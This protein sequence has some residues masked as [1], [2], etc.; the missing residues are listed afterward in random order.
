MARRGTGAPARA[1]APPRAARAADVDLLQCLILFDE[2][3]DGLYWHHRILLY[4]G[5]EQ[6]WLWVTP[7]EEIQLGD[8]AEHVVIPLRRGEP[9]PERVRGEAY[10]FRFVTPDDVSRYLEEAK[11]LAHILNI[12][13]NGTPTSGDKWF[14]SDPRSE[15]YGDQIPP[16]ALQ[17]QEILIRRGRL[18]AHRGLLDD[19]RPCRRGKVLRR[20]PPGDR[21]RQRAGPEGVGGN[22]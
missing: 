9:L 22:S 11:A 18:G 14:V 12:S 10:A 21:R 2:D 5:T 16:S 1:A 4:R 7:D 19:V 15:S 20:L 13:V 3:E 8:L 17:S 6:K